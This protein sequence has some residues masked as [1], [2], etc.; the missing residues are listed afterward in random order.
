[1]KA[2]RGD[3]QQ[4]VFAQLAENPFCKNHIVGEGW[5]CMLIKTTEQTIP[6]FALRFQ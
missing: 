3:S 4:F 5:C 2:V 1:M 6:L